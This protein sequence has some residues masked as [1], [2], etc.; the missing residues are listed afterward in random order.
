MGLPNVGI[1]P[2]LGSR[3]LGRTQ[4]SSSQKTQKQHRKTTLLRRDLAS[5]Q[6]NDRKEVPSES[7]QGRPSSDDRSLACLHLYVIAWCSH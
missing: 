5:F 3:N 6:E 2:H 7:L 4:V 1:R